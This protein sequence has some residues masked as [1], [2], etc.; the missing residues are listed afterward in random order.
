MLQTA[1][2]KRKIS[3]HTRGK[4]KMPNGEVI[5]MRDVV[6]KITKWVKMFVAVG[7][8]ATTYH[9]EPAALPWAAMRCITQP[10]TYETE[11]HGSMV[12]NLEMI[13]RLLPRYREFERL[14]LGT[15]TAV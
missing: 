5:I 9:P 12:A 6:E 3:I 8:V 11:G 10:A 15:A 2:Q 13:S 7:D 14:H 1:E 4:F